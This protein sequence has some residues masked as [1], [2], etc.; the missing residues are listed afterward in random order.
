MSVEKER[1]RDDLIIFF[2]LIVIISI[3]CALHPYI[4]FQLMHSV[5]SKIKFKEDVVIIKNKFH[6]LYISSSLVRFKFTRLSF[7]SNIC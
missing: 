3:Y 7:I 6:Y 4:F 1:E 2:S 5:I